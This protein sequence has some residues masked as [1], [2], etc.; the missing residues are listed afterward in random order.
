M[1]TDP[2]YVAAVVA[3]NGGQVPKGGK[4]TPLS[5][6]TPEVSLLAMVV[7]ELRALK[8]ITIS[9]HSAKGSAAPR[10]EQVP[11]PHT[12]W[13]DVVL[14]QR[15]AKHDRLAGKLLGSRRRRPPP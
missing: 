9:A 8:A 5:Q 10:P 4:A 14:S 3:S 7:D 11:R 6:W 12:A 1:A 2:E 15:L 13:D